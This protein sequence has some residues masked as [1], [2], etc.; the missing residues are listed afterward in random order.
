VL[1]NSGDGGNGMLETAK[2]KEIVR[3]EK[4]GKRKKETN[5]TNEIEVKK[6]QM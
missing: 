6:E 2:D 1:H 4:W 5:E 3:R